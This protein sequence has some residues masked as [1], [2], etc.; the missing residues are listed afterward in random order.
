MSKWILPNLN[1][2]KRLRSLHLLPLNYY[3]VPTDL[4]LL[5]KSLNNYYAFDI[6]EHIS[7]VQR[8][9]SNGFVLP[10]IEKFQRSIFS[11]S[12]IE[13]KHHWFKC[14]I[15]STRRTQKL[16]LN[17]HVEV[18]QFLLRYEKLVFHSIY[19]SLQK[20]SFIEWNKLNKT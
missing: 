16:V 18:L 11:A 10:E 15:L 13:S 2:R 9:S 20:M 5:S 17:L 1:Y 7:I 19:L 3:I 6:S 14:E 12:Y 8:R 4:L